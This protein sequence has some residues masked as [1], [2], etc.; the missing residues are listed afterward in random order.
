MGLTENDKES[1]DIL[2]QAFDT[3]T[4]DK[5]LKSLFV[6]LMINGMATN[7]WEL[8]QKFKN[9]LCSD[10]MRKAEVTG[11]PTAEM[12]NIL[13]LE[14]KDLFEELDEDM[15]FYFGEA[16]M[17]TDVPKE[18]SI[19]QEYQCEV[20]YDLA[21]EIEKAANNKGNYIIQILLLVCHQKNCFRAS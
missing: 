21:V 1:E 17:P 7:P 15:A 2:T 16:N 10:Q 6:N 14:L 9:Q 3:I 19:P 11:E 8:F 5:A 20:E 13:L 12:V 18:K 4:N